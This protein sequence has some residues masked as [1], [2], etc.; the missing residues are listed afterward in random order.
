MDGHDGRP[1]GPLASR[2]T[3]VD[4]CTASVDGPL[5]YRF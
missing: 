2:R 3:A 1:G 4:R 5:S